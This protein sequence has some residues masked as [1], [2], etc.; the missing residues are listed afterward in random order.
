VPKRV[1]K[2]CPRPGR[3]HLPFS[4]PFS[5]LFF[6][7]HFPRISCRTPF[8]SV[9]YPFCVGNGIVTR[10]VA[11]LA[12]LPPYPSHSFVF[13]FGLYPRIS[14]VSC[15]PCARVPALRIHFPATHRRV[16]LRLSHFVL[17]VEKRKKKRREWQ[18]GR[19]R[20]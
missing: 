14:V 15:I 7:W 10:R 5:H 9:F 8:F 18:K 3:S 12:Y 16:R 11:R 20:A 1:E 6:F 19:K 17:L 4:C 2:G 13:I